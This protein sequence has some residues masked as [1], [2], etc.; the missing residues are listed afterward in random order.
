MKKIIVPL[1]FSEQSEYALKV[2]A[3]LA[4][5]HGSEIL[6]LHMLELNQAMISSSE[7]FHP[8]QTVFL[9][10]LAEKRFNKF[11]DK[12]YLKGIQLT[13]IIKHFKVFSEVN[14]VAKEH[15]AEL[16]VMGSH[17]T[18]GLKE[19][20]VGSNAER[21]VRNADIPVLVIKK[22]I[23]DFKV[24]RFVFASDFKEE[25]LLAFQKA[26]AFADMLSADLDMV[27]VNTPG[28]SFLSTADTYE[29][30]NQFLAKANVGIEVSIY[31]DYS[32]ERGILNYSENSGADAIGIP[33]H[34]RKGL[35][36]FFM[37]SIGEDIANHSDLPVV[38]FKI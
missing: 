26:K 18:D 11:L 3:S 8:E 14:E 22:E 35:S 12:P 32:V 17:G 10:K 16:I 23:K 6:A 38:T 13:P 20:F 15:N 29:R 31:N 33:T 7:G 21:V 2:A 36:H 34:G 24:D 27:Y 1:D 37:G 25:N 30:I 28:D 9:I 4:K 5:K 19:I